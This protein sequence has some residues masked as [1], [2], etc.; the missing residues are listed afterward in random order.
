MNLCY[1]GMSLQIGEAMRGSNRKSK[2]PGI[3]AVV[4][5]AVLMTAVPF[6][7]S[8]SAFSGSTEEE[9]LKVLREYTKGGG[10]PPESVVADI[11]NRFSRTKTGSLAKIMRARI[12]LENGDFP[13]AVGI[14]DDPAV[15]Q[16]TNLADYVL[17]LKGRAFQGMG[18][19]RNAMAQFSKLI[20]SYPDSLRL[21]ESKTMWAASAI[22]TGRGSE[23][24]TF[25]AEFVKAGNPAAMLAVAKAHRAL[26]N[27]AEATALFRRVFFFAAGT[28]EAKEAESM[29]ASMSQ[30]L[31]PLG[32]DE[33]RSRADG[34]L[35]AGD[36]AGASASY[37]ALLRT[38]PASADA[39]LHLG[40]MTALIGLRQMTEARSAFDAIGRGSA[41]RERAYP[42][43]AAGYVRSGSWAQARA[44]L[45]AFA[46]DYPKS[47]ELAKGFVDAGNAARDAKN[48]AEESQF[49]AEALRRFP[50]SVE[51]AAA[52]FELAWL[53][54]EAGRFDTSW[55]LL[56][57]HLARYSSRNSSFR[58]RSG[59]W[60]ARDAQRAGKT[61]EACA[62]YEALIHRYASNWY[63]YV[64]QERLDSLRESGACRQP[65]GDTL[66]PSVRAAAENLKTVTVASSE[67]GRRD[68]VRLDK[69]DELGHIGLFDW[70][71]NELQAA[72]RT[73]GS[74][75]GVARAL[76][77]HHRLKDDNVSA[78]LALAKAY[79]D[80]PQMF[81]EEMSAEDWDIFYPLRHWG[82]IKTWAGRRNLD[83]YKVAGLIRQ[84]SVFNPRARSSANAFGLMQLLVPTARLVA[85]KYSSET[86]V[87]SADTL[88]D[89][90]VN[91][92]LGTAYMRD[93]LEKYGRIEYMAAAYNAGPGR[94]TQWRSTL[95][96][97]ID[98]FVEAIPFRETRMYVQGVVRNTAQYRRLYD[99]NGNFRANVGTRAGG[100]QR[101]VATK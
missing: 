28:K 89:P 76:A 13:A 63:G 51:V 74:S 72:Q 78:F 6:S 59:Y 40:R 66:D 5:G 23:V 48:R 11:E 81:P 62:L 64:G 98:E 27:Q 61:V 77:R 42:R 95:P 7:I 19:H 97:D 16:R 4:I 70:S 57:E 92:E 52:Q 22:E 30:S 49:F 41:E 9:A 14:L 80:Y 67:I 100:R 65:E 32:A 53:E 55:R 39:G 47:G 29:L 86:S 91:I 1:S 2:S 73:A 34:L 21:A 37:A 38:F 82:E 33:L 15:V 101:I 31:E 90:A 75:L 43:L 87:I 79:P 45:V 50:D 10:L 25:L 83:P 94:M 71:M 84:E 20:E 18:D 85:R 96:L 8:C 93:Q 58:G 68:L 17:W 88:Y 36:N 46:A 12:R 35:L 69:A 44:V 60:A 26:G 99:E 3:A 56:V 54:H 24:P